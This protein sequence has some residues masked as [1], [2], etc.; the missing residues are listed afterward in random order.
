MAR[1]R[2][3]EASHRVGIVLAVVL[4]F[5]LLLTPDSGTTPLQQI[6]R[7]IRAGESLWLIPVVIGM[8]LVAS[9]AIYVAT[10]SAAWLAVWLI[11]GFRRR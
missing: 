7:S 9:G 4:F 11:D 8:F 5:Y 1:S 10:R 2:F 6:G 3:Q